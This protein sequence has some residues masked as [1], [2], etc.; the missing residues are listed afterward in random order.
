MPEEEDEVAEGTSSQ[1]DLTVDPPTESGSD[2]SGFQPQPPT[3]EGEQDTDSPGAGHIPESKTQWDRNPTKPRRE[4]TPDPLGPGERDSDDRGN[5]STSHNL[6]T[7]SEI[8]ER[9]VKRRRNKRVKKKK[10]RTPEQ[11]G[12]NNE[13]GSE[14]NHLRALRN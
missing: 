8:E 5:P 11:V 7:D 2:Q 13:S 10:V 6:D 12:E 3:R 4:L 1:A 9:V 14:S